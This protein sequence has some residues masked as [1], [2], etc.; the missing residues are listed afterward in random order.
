M[1]ND[2]SACCIGNAVLDTSYYIPF[3]FATD[4]AMN[5]ER[6]VCG[7][8]FVLRTCEMVACQWDVG[9]QLVDVKALNFDWTANSYS[10]LKLSF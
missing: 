4:D 1:H 5:I 2:G 8:Y 3:V 7:F 10:S 9:I 6:A